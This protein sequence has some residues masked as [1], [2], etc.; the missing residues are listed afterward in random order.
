MIICIEYWKGD[1]FL[2]GTK[3]PVSELRNQL[4][5]VERIYDKA[6]DNFVSLL[7]RV[8]GWNPVAVDRDMIPDFTYDR[9][10]GLIF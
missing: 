1:T 5:Q 4:N 9:D 8:Y 6:E 3:I 7:C 2:T 10:T